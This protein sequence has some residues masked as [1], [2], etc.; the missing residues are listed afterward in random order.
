MVLGW[1]A[2]PLTV[3][4]PAAAVIL[5]QAVFGPASVDTPLVTFTLHPHWAYALLVPLPLLAFYGAV[6]GLGELITAIARR[7]LGP[8]PPSGSPPWRSAPS[9]SWNA[10]ASPVSCTTRSVT[11]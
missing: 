10:A 11:R 5:V 7:L 6:V 2:G 9:N 3:W 4:L 1:V 8:S